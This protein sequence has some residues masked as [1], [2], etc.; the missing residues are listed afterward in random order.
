MSRQQQIYCNNIN[1]VATRLAHETVHSLDGSCED[2]HC[3]TLNRTTNAL[4]PATMEDTLTKDVLHASTARAETHELD[5]RPSQGLPAY[6]SSK[7]SSSSRRVSIEHRRARTSSLATVMDIAGL[8]ANP[9]ATINKA[10]AEMDDAKLAMRKQSN[11][12]SPPQT[13]STTIWRAFVD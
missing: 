9:S 13:H 12:A 11:E 2:V 1:S 4:P 6:L 3:G 7:S 8:E 10:P 5:V